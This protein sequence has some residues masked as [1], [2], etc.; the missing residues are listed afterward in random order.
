MKKQR[1]LN[2]LSQTAGPCRA[3]AFDVFDTL[4]FRDT[5]RPSDVFRLMERPALR[6]AAWTPR[7]PPAAR[8]RK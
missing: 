1:L 5:A 4:L 8:M 7:P 6:S 2:I 3:V